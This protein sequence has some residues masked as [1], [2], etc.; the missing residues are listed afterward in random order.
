MACECV[1]RDVRG[2]G[3]AQGSMPHSCA[4]LLTFYKSSG[5]NSISIVVG[6]ASDISSQ[7]RT[8]E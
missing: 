5:R 3:E 1:Q 6:F 2:G 7:K 4:I 8:S